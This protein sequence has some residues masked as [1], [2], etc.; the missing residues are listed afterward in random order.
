MTASCMMEML[1]LRVVTGEPAVGFRRTWTQRPLSQWHSA[2]RLVIG[3]LLLATRAKSLTLKWRSSNRKTIERSGA[4]V[5]GRLLWSRGAQA[6]LDH[7]QQPRALMY[8][9]ACQK[10]V[11]ACRL[12]WSNSSKSSFEIADKLPSLSSTTTGT[13]TALT[14]LQISPR[15]P[16]IPELRQ[17][18]A[19]LQ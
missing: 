18:A 10:H 6:H 11:I 12:F 1:R 8:L 13:R 5:T 17:Q 4:A 3:S 9:S 16:R 2:S 14:V 19:R 15:H 7:H